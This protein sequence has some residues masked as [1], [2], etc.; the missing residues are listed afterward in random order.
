MKRTLFLISLIAALCITFPTA[1]LA[2]VLNNPGFETGD[3]TDWNSWGN[4]QVSGDVYRTGSFSAQSWAWGGTNGV[5]QDITSAGGEQVDLS[6]YIAT[7]I[8]SNTD[9]YVAVEFY[10]SSNAKLNEV[11]GAA[12]ASGIDWTY[13]AISEIAPTNTAYARVMLRVDESAAN[14]SGSVFFDD[15]SADS[16]AVPEP[17]SLLL[18]GSGLFGLAGISRKKKQ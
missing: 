17:A 13:Y 11:R 18:L 1:A 10:D 12:A 4:F 5:W 14:P 9:A 8:L 16:N 7:D 15:I 3:F 2:N 6:A